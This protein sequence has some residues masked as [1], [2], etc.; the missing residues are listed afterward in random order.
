MDLV[1]VPRS[2][3]FQQ[4]HLVF[5]SIIANFDRDSIKSIM[6]RG[7][8]KTGTHHSFGASTCLL[9]PPPSYF[10]VIGIYYGWGRVLPEI[11][12]YPMV[13]SSGWNP[14]YGNTER[15]VEAHL[16][17]ATLAPFY[18]AKLRIVVSGYLRPE[19]Q[20][21]SKGMCFMIVCEHGVLQKLSSITNA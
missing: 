3:A 21:V 9:L 16:I 12:T 20:Y 7:L 14:H 2:W 10:P 1:A 13:M 11:T 4:V 6:E 8:T 19:Q 5:L 15:S 17:N 18:G